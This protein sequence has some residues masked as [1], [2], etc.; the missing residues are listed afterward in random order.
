MMLLANVWT[1]NHPGNPCQLYDAVKVKT[2][3]TEL[4]KA[5]HW[6]VDI[7][8]VAWV[9]ISTCSSFCSFGF[10]CRENNSTD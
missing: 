1:E 3:N 5:Y 7:V 6:H 8:R 4:R 10:S 2:F 9:V